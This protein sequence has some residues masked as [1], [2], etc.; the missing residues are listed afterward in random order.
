MKKI[1]VLLMALAIAM[2]AK[3]DINSADVK[4]LQAL[5]GV[6]E[7]KAEQIVE[8]RKKNGEFK[9]VDDLK[10]VSGIGQKILD[11]N[12]NEIEAKPVLKASAEANKTKK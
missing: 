6:G 12:K 1:L 10:K 4:T 7:K 11:D 8:F 5:K 9:S 2:F 3:V